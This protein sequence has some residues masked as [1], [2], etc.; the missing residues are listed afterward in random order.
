MNIAIKPLLAFKIQEQDD[1]HLNVKLFWGML[2][3][4]LYLGVIFQGL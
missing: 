1:F 2:A 3:H 4:I